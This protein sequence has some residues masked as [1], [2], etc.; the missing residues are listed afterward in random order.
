MGMPETVAQEMPNEE[1]IAKCVWLTEE[2]LRVYS[3][4]FKSTGFQG[5]PKGHPPRP[6]TLT[7]RAR[8]TP[9]SNKKRDVGSHFGF[10]HVGAEKQVVSSSGTFCTPSIT[11]SPCAASL[12][13]AFAISLN[14]TLGQE[15]LEAA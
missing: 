14:S 1:T 3:D 9:Y 11:P 5:G 7:P 15:A 2:E 13:S 4:A 6:R 10:K 8:Q 12:C